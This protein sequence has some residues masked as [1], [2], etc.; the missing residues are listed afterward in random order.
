M[1]SDVMD[2]RTTEAGDQERYV[3]TFIDD[4]SRFGLTSFAK[5]K[6]EARE[7]FV[8]LATLVENQQSTTIKTL[9]T[10]RGGEYLSGNMKK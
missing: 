6:S 4:Y 8:E 3:I 9:P 7:K 1:H 2:V 5:S 10:D